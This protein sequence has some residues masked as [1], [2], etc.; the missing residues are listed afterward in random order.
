M[1]CRLIKSIDLSIDEV[2]MGEIVQSYGDESYLTEGLPDVRK[3]DPMAFT[4]HDN[5]Y[6]KLGE[7]VGKAWSIGKNF[8]K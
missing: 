7:K 1:E 8:I 2:F 3:M 6:W 4:I 5:S